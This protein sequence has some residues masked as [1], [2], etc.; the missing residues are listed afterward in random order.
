MTTQSDREQIMNKIAADLRI[1]RRGN[2]GAK[3]PSRALEADWDYSAIVIHNTGHGHLDTMAKIQKFDLTT[4]NWDDVSY[5]YGIM[6]NG[7][8]FEGRQLIYKGAD[9]R[10][11]NTGKIG[12]VCIGDYD[13]TV[14]NWL[15]GRSCGGDPV[16]PKMLDALRRLTVRLSKS[17]QITYFGGHIEYGDTTDCPGSSMLPYMAKFRKDFNFKV[18]V[19]RS[20][21]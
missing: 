5:H 17:F 8:I 3:R 21:L 7:T 9:V 20:G 18:P 11:Q 12:I 15:Y 2:W 10:N 19:K 1:V 6:P 4:R 14:V 13:S 16:M